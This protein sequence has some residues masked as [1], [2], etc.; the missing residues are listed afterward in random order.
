MSSQGQH[1]EPREPIDYRSLAARIKQWASEL[2]FEATGITDTDLARAGSRLKEWLAAGRHGEMQY[3]AAHGNRRTEPASLVP[4][5][6]RVICVRMRYWPGDSALPPDT[7][8]ADRGAGYVARYALGKDYHKVLRRRLQKLADRIQEQVGSFGY[9]AF[10]DSAPVMEK[11]LAEK[12]GLGW[13]GKHTNLIDKTQGSWFFLG[14]LFT[15]LP[16]PVDEAAENH[17]GSCRACLDACPTGA[18]TAPY[19]LDARRCISYL[20]IELRGSI[21]ELLRPLMG[22]RIFG[23]DDC[24]AVCPWNRFARVSTLPELRPRTAVTDRELE[25]F[26]SWTEEEFDRHT[27]G[28]AIRRAGYEGFLR[29]VA[30]ALGNAPASSAV[31]A[32]IEKLVRHSS[33]LVREHAEWA[34]ARHCRAA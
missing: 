27:A 7:A 2:G 11:P 4:G 5:T 21:P 33:P 6:L 19:Q 30:V 26:A 15:D 32:S 3:M 24:Q 25:W 28:S 20:T 16:L 18:I 23:C 17:C 34:R 13:I 14:E 22:N 8:L 10:A 29:N 12:A 1:G 31:L 9:R